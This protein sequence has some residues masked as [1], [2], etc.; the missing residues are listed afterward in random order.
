MKLFKFSQ[1]FVFFNFWY[2][3]TESIMVFS[4]HSFHIPTLNVSHDG[5]NELFFISKGKRFN[6]DYF[7]DTTNLNVH[8][9]YVGINRRKKRVRLKI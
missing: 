1:M 2:T 5:L 7:I 9:V 3:S 4:C 6:T 8:Y